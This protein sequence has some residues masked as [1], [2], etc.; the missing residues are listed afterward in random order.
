MIVLEAGRIVYDRAAGVIL[1]EAGAPDFNSH[2]DGFC[3]AFTLRV[4]GG[5]RARGARLNAASP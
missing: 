2:V 1:T 4:P 3:A 5:R